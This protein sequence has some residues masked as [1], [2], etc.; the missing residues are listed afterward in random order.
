[1]PKGT[2]S[3]WIELDG[4][5]FLL[6]KDD[7]TGGAAMS[8]EQAYDRIAASVKEEAAKKLYTEWLDLLKSETYIKVY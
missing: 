3:Q 4:W 2:I 8:F 1:M 7:E 5:S 6:R